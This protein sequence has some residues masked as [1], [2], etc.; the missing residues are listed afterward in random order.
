MKRV[1]CVLLLSVKKKKLLQTMIISTDE[2]CEIKAS[3]L[4]T[5]N[6]ITVRLIINQNSAFEKKLN[7]AFRKF[8]L[9]C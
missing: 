6:D 1:F 3:K 2:V 7:Q 8:Q 9:I 4:G 5:S